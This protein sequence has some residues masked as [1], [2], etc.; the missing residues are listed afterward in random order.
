MNVQCVM[1]GNKIIVK[2]DREVRILP[3]YDNIM[4]I[5]V[6]ENV[7]ELLKFY[8]R[9]DS[10]RYDELQE[11]KNVTT[12]TGIKFG[13]GCVAVAAASALLGVSGSIP[14]AYAIT[15]GTGA[16][17]SIGAYSLLGMVFANKKNECDGLRECLKFQEEKMAKLEKQIVDSYANGVVIE[18][19]E[20]T[21]YVDDRAEKDRLNKI[22]SFVF[23]MGCHRAKVASI[24]K[25]LNLHSFLREKFGISDIKS[26]CEIEYYVY[27]EFSDEFEQASGYKL[28]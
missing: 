8:Y 14:G 23:Y 20:D 26:I 18:K 10:E 7:L 19:N 11:V 25:D 5:L 6:Q 2:A 9:R 15:V 27:R 24:V 3:N 4:D 28:K 1:H 21:I 22:L 13:T 17:A 16:M 12:S